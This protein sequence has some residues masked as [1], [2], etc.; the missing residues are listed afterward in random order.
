MK[1]RLLPVLILLATLA[2]CATPTPAPTPLPPPTRTPQ[3]YATVVVSRPTRTEAPTWT[4]QPTRT[5]RPTNTVAP[6]RT[7]R[8]T[9]TRVPSATPAG[10]ELGLLTEDGLITVLL[11][12]EDFNTALTAERENYYFGAEINRAGETK[13][14][15]R[16]MRIIVNFNN[17]TTNGQPGDFT[18]TLRAFNGEVVVDLI[19]YESRISTAISPNQAGLARELI[20][21]AIVDRAIPTVI[22]RLQPYLAETKVQSIRIAPDGVLITA[23][24]TLATPTPTPTITETAEILPSVTLTPSQTFTALPTTTPLGGPT[25]TLAPGQATPI[26]PTATATPTLGN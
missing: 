14:E 10:G 7:P 17:F 16:R 19:T 4:P 12:A 11:K 2:A 21:R 26:T 13:F 25:L 5:S 22:K 23:K 8:P 6:T 9:N 20:R 1:N 18:L 15:D 24:I 3:I